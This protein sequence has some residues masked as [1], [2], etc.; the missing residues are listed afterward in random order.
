MFVERKLSLVSRIDLSVGVGWGGVINVF[1]PTTSGFQ[2]CSSS[3]LEFT[4]EKMCNRFTHTHYKCTRRHIIDRS[5]FTNVRP[6]LRNE[7]NIPTFCNWHGS[8]QERAAKLYVR[9]EK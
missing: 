4:L 5:G 1:V 3:R 7:T 2:L 6:T 9:R 8:T